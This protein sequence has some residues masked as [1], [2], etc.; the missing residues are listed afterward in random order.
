MICFHVSIRNF[1]VLY[2]NY[3]AL[4]APLLDHPALRA[5]LQRRGITPPLWHGVPEMERMT[6][7]G[8]AD[9]EALTGFRGTFYPNFVKS[10]IDR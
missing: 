10:L 1:D 3:P 5:P 6:Y 7:D 8:A 4:R 2:Y 9:V